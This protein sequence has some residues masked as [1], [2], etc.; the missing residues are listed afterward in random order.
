M[1]RQT[2]NRATIAAAVSGV[3][4]LLL[5]LLWPRSE[6]T[7]P[8]QLT[9][10]D[11]LR[12]AEAEAAW[13][14]LDV[15]TAA[16]ELGTPEAAAAFLRNHVVLQDYAGRF[17]AAG[18][19]LL[20]RGANA[21]DQAALLQALVEDQGYPTRLME[22]DWP[23]AP[24]DRLGRPSRVRPA[25]LA[26]QSYLGLEPSAEAEQRLQ[27]ARTRVEGLRQE[28]DA[29][30]ALLAAE[31]ALAEPGD[32]PRPDRRLIVDYQD[33]SGNWNA[34]DPVFDVP[35]G[36]TRPASA[37][38][39][40]PV[41]AHLDLVTAEG[42]RR[43]LIDFPLDASQ[44]AHLSF[45]PASGYEAFLLGPPDPT[46]I[47][48]WRPVFQQGGRA[49]AG[50]PFTPDGRPASLPGDPGF[51]IP[52]PAPST[53]EITD[54]DLK[55]WPEVALS[56]RT[57]APQNASWRASHV[58]LSEDDRPRR[59]R[60]E[61]LPAP[62]RDIAVITDVS[63]SMVEGGRIFVAGEVGRAL[64][65]RTARPQQIAA[66]TAAGTPLLQRQRSI[67]FQPQDAIDDFESGL[68]IRPGDDLAPAIGLA[69]ESFYGPIDVV[70]I[71]DGEVTEEQL[72]AVDAL[73]DGDRLRIHAVVPAL[74]AQRFQPVT[75]SVFILPDTEAGAADL[76][77][78]IAEMAGSHL[79]ISFVAE[80]GN[81]G[82]T[83]ELALAFAGSDVTA[84]AAY[85]IP[86]SPAGQS[87]LE[88]FLTR[89]GEPLGEARTL[90]QL[91]GPDAGWR[92]MAEHVLFVSG[93]RFD[94]DAMVRAFYGRE[95]FIF[96]M[97]LDDPAAAPP[98]GVDFMYLAAAQQVTGLT[99][100]GS[101]SPI[102]GER[103]QA[104]LLT[105]APAERG[106]DFAMTTRLDLLSDG[107]LGDAG[108]ARAGLA[109]GAAEAAV[110]GGGSVNI[111][112]IEGDRE[113][114]DPRTPIP[115]T[116]PDEAARVL[117]GTRRTVMATSDGMAGWLA[118]PDGRIS[119]RLFQPA[120]KGAS[121]EEIVQTF[122]RIRT[123][124]GISG[125]VASGL[126]SPYNVPGAKV[127]ALTAIL[128]F[129]VRLFCASSVMMGFVNEAIERGSDGDED[130]EGY[131]QRRCEI[132]LDSPLYD[133][134][135]SVASSATQGWYGDRYTDAA[136]AA[137]GPAVTHWREVL[138]NSEAGILISQLVDLASTSEALQ[139]RRPDPLPGRAYALNQAAQMSESRP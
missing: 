25:H 112:L 54:V 121:V 116:W 139:Q 2:R 7:D 107:G 43:R 6:Q 101:G 110:L 68:T 133:L 78:A 132:D 124:L 16:A 93:G 59:A 83:R 13:P 89:A 66:A 137:G 30:Y 74:Q 3:V 61:A 111:R 15:E 29:A 51:D 87:R 130:W 122:D 37:G 126:L 19:V 97:G 14:G 49:E 100:Q 135:G 105:A 17:A 75:D 41:T 98:P 21:E 38:P 52:A 117:R 77:R 125:A 108:G 34:L 99:E 109:V 72:E 28:V 134:A 10:L 86:A 70:V 42:A 5:F 50:A 53:A 20:T 58:R 114:V 12:A 73:R 36:R 40:E 71:T 80:P 60:I 69:A 46:T 23:E 131:A 22:A 115:E 33:A 85:N 129:D 63:P 48:L 67:F 76:G 39:V 82:E 138:I 79:R 32:Q 11:L 104:L 94:V 35:V 4:I 24:F 106:E 113:V 57:N 44:Q 102:T 90:A 31:V 95:R 103:L 88:L 26:V 18:D 27:E 45:V 120:A 47:A 118:E 84:Q 55:A 64:I 1:T 8:E 92:L 91:G 96:E 9:L 56:V 81:V 65:A 128:D 119:V 136:K 62:P 127:G 123:G